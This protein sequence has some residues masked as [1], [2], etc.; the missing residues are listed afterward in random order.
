[1]SPRRPP[2]AANGDWGVL[3]RRGVAVGPAADAPAVPPL[4]SPPSPVC[5]GGPLHAVCSP[6]HCVA[7]CLHSSWFVA[8]TGRYPAMKLPAS[9]SPARRQR[10]SGVCCYDER[11]ARCELGP[12]SGGPLDSPSA[13]AHRT[14]VPSVSVRP[15]AIRPGFP[16]QS[17]LW[18]QRRQ[19]PLVCCCPSHRHP[20]AAVGRCVSSAHAAPALR[21]GLAASG[22]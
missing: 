17:Q 22:G 19:S 10:R 14:G 3:L 15:P 13:A 6:S 11:S 12:P 4:P 1:M 2:P 18:V 9:S 16:D 8:A 5:I 21:R 7:S 20:C